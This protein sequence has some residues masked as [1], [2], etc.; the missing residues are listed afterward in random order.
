[1]PIIN[2]VLENNVR[3]D[4][5]IESLIRVTAV[6]QERA[7]PQALRT[8]VR[9]NGYADIVISSEATSLDAEVKGVE[10]SGRVGLIKTYIVETEITG[11]GDFLQ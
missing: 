3:G 1:M 10:Y 11:A 4:G 2:R 7:G 5:T 9:H 8:A 6:R